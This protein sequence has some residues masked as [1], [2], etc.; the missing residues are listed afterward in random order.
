MF[1]SSNRRSFFCCVTSLAIVAVAAA[2]LERPDVNVAV[3]E[4]GDT[5]QIDYT[6]G[7]HQEVA[8]R[9]DGAEYAV[10]KL[11]DESQI[12]KAGAP[13]IP[14]V[15]RSVLISDRAAMAVRV[16]GGDYV[17]YANV[18][19]APSKGNFT[20]DIDPATVP[21]VF[22]EAYETDAF[23]PGT[24]A[25]LSDPYVMRDHRG[26]VVRVNPVQYNPVTQ[27]L[28]VYRT[29][30]VELTDTG[31][32]AVNP[33]VRPNRPNTL[34]RA[35]HNIY[36]NHFVNYGFDARYEP[37][38][39]QG[40]LLIIAADQFVTQMGE[41]VDHKNNNVG[42][43]TTM[44]PL[45]AVGSTSAAI[46]SYIQNYYNANDLAFVLLV[47]D[48][49]Q[50][51]PM[52]SSAAYGDS[53]PMYAK[54]A[55]NDQYPDIIVGRFSASNAADLQTQIDR[56]IAYEVDA[57]TTTDWFKRGVGI[58]SDEGAGIGDDGE[59]DWEHL[60]N[61][62]TDLMGIG[63]TIVD[64]IY[65]PTATISQISAAVNA[66]RGIINYTGHGSV[67]SWGTTGFSNTN[68]NALTNTN[69]L[70][71]IV[72]VACVNG[73][74]AGQTCFAE[75]W[76][77]AT[78]NGEPTGAVLIYASTI[79][80][81]WAPP[82]SAQDEIVDRFVDDTEPYRCC[83]ALC[84]AGSC[85]MMDEYGND[86]SGAGTEMYDTWTIFGDPTLCV[87]GT[88]AP[89]TGLTISGAALGALGEPGGPFTPDSTTYTL[90][91]NDLTALNF[92]VG[93]DVDWLDIAPTA[94]SIPALGTV[95][96]TVSL[97][98]NANGYEHG[99]YTASIDFV[100]TTNGDGDATKYATLNVDAVVKQIEFTF[101]S[102]PGW[103]TEG[104]WAFGQ[105][106][107]QAGDHGEPDPTSG[108]TGPYVYGYNL[109]G[110]YTNSMGAPMALISEPIDCSNLVDTKLKFQRWLNIES[111][112]WD[113]ADLYVSNNGSTWTN[114]WSNPGSTIADTSWTQVEYDIASVADEQAT[115]YLKWTI[116]PTDSIWTF[117]GW[118]IDDVEIW[119][120]ALVPNI[121]GDLSGDGLVDSVDLNLLLSAWGCDNCDEDIT[122]DGTVDANDLNIVLSNWN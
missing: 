56:S 95:E 16:V 118:N 17:D 89:P 71:F 31:A 111:S 49:E 119:G 40:E 122:G 109:N 11:G 82:M 105:P 14:D 88:I 3:T 26:V 94:G 52:W 100:N 97:N 7:M 93:T 67:T 83:G 103:T 28:R 110:G 84:F 6:F 108:H 99:T 78:H 72:S 79:N 63:Y 36:K 8:V 104:Q 21:Y 107:G 91:N 80:Q 39:E 42:L 90:T 85:L 44:V 64:Q 4:R 20:R 76:V 70:P 102:D 60:N 120:A 27:T 66:G 73:D 51:P 30:T 25:S 33:L 62:R 35:F 112:S 38:D 92:T 58:G 74:F 18:L 15:A 10:I 96:V 61:I 23:Y 77:R 121:P 50:V 1:T 115:V 32:E 98:A 59:T 68:V 55:G 87:I 86:A 13:D 48:A 81:S 9:V 57:A 12:L 37:L 47:G 43:P 106:T 65:E 45:S 53:D 22:G 29:M 54:L 46:K 34:S 75:A 5:I 116:G 114:L 69:E 101:D 2:G 41:F 117:A 24:L 113:H 19:V